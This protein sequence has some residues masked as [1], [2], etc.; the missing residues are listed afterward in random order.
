M[1]LHH[2]TKTLDL[3]TTSVPDASLLRWRVLLF[4][5]SRSGSCLQSDV[6]A[7]FGMNDVEAG[8]NVNFWTH[9]KSDQTPGIHFLEYEQD[10]R[11]RRAK[12]ITVTKLGKDF[13][14]QLEAIK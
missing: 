7:E 6:A 5:F 1:S 13:L 9:R 14:R 10:P 11:D 3:L 4:I 12:S 2:V 8:R